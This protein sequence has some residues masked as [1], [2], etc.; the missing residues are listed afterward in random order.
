MKYEASK[1]PP[2]AC[3]DKWWQLGPKI[4]TF[5][6]TDDGAAAVEFALVAIPF[7]V[8]VGA[9][10]ELTIHFF[11]SSVMN[12]AVAD[13]ARELRTNQVTA[14]T[15]SEAEFKQYLC[16]KPMMAM[17]NCDNLIV[18]VQVVATF[19]APGI[20]RNPNGTINSAGM[21]FNPGGTGSRSINILRVYYEWPTFMAFSNFSN[22]PMW[23]SGNRLMMSSEAFKLEPV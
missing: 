12:T 11:V 10:F 19:G 15:H 22:D 14:G 20:P 9:I 6:R 21:G 7:F 1:S 17:F 5:R 23:A 2:R 13:M 4:K 18:D 8:F 3:H 16:D